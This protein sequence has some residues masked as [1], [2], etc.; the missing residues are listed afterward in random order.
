MQHTLR[1]LTIATFAAFTGIATF[2]GPLDLDEK[3]K[4]SVWQDQKNRQTSTYADDGAGGTALRFTWDAGGR[5][6]MESLFPQQPP[7]EGF[8]P[9]M[10][11]SLWLLDEPAG[12]VRAMALRVVDASGEVFQFGQK[13][14]RSADGWQKVTWTLDPAKAE[15]IYQGDGNKQFDGQVKW[16]GIL[17]ITEEEVS[18][19]VHL[20]V[21]ADKGGEVEKPAAKAPPEDATANRLDAPPAEAILPRPLVDVSKGN[22]LNPNRGKQ[23]QHE[24][25]A[26]E[27]FGQLVWGEGAKPL[28]EAVVGGS[29]DLSAYEAGIELSIPINADELAGFSKMAIR[30]R[31]ARGEIFQWPVRINPD[32]SGWQDVRVPLDRAAVEANYGGPADSRGVVNAPLKL[33]SLLFISPDGKAGSLKLGDISRNDFDAADISVAERMADVKVDL[34]RT[35]NIPLFDASKNEP[36]SL[37]LTNESQAEATFDLVLNLTHFD[38][39][40]KTV[41]RPGIT[42]AGG[43]STEVQVADELKKLGWYSLVPVLK[44]GDEA[45]N[46]PGTSFVYLEP[47]G[48]RAHPPEE[49][50]WLGIDVRIGNARQN[51]WPA[52]L[53]ALIGAD[54]FRVGNTWPRIQRNEGE[55]NT[56]Q[57]EAE[58]AL[59]AEHGLK[60][61]YGLTFTPEWAVLPG[62]REQLEERIRER[63]LSIKPKGASTMP[64]DPEAWRQFVRQIAAYNR[65]KNVI[66]YEVW[67]E[68]DLSGF[69]MGTTD[70]FLELMRIANEEVE[71]NHPESTMLGAGIATLGGHGGHNL[72]PDMITRSIVEGA[73][74]Y[75]AMAIHQHGHFAEFSRQIDGRIAG[76]REKIEV[77]KPLWFTET[78]WAGEDRVEQ[79][80]QLV[81]KI[82]F[83]R[84]RGAMGFT[85]FVLQMGP[86]DRYAMLTS[87]KDPQ[88]HPQLAAFNEL[89]KMMR[90]RTFVKQHETS[91][92]A[93]VLEFA[94]KADRLLVAWAEEPSA[95]GQTVVLAVPQETRVQR[96]DIM[97]NATAMPVTNGMVSVTLDR[98][99]QYVL[100]E[101][102]QTGV[103]GALAAFTQPVVGF[104]GKPAEAVAM[105]KNPTNREATYRIRWSA[106]GNEAVE[107]DVTIAAG[108]SQEVSYELTVPAIAAG[109]AEPVVTLAYELAGTSLTGTL[110]QAVGVA[111]L[112]SA[113]PAAGREPDFVLDTLDRTV[114]NVNQADPNRRQ[115]VWTGPED[116]SARIWLQGGAEA[117]ELVVEVTDDVHAQTQAPGMLWKQDSLQ[118]GIALPGQEGFFEFGFALSNGKASSAA[119]ITPGLPDPTPSFDVKVEKTAD[120]V[121][122]HI[123]MPYEALGVER[124]ALVE[125]GLRFNAVI[126]DDDGGDREGWAQVSDGMARSK[127]VKLW[128]RIVFE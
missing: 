4:L 41:T 38:G 28:L 96:F 5:R 112:V 30:A 69:Y 83:A 103:A 95:Q 42:L 63:G 100:A 122:Y 56:S 32:A 68:P 8:E 24:F 124:S 17:A 72:N 121:R 2:A 23:N 39:T 73:P 66:A 44:V 46:K 37:T 115:Y 62:Y 29:P 25:K 81:K 16:Y 19:P 102:P 90:G 52:E 70:Q 51:R 64:P 104:P 31:D 71:A 65:G 58:L 91:P 101:S 15:N 50:F 106:P 36:I 54:Y 35:A 40:E 43:A 7:I 128:P 22:A 93:W 49:G 55:F 86:E 53:G 127:D 105:L 123:R 78:G 67:N 47:A 97:G 116:L 20:W 1:R 120:G 26:G 34:K 99:V 125:Q 107:K 98:P 57:H 87:G 6:L 84:A 110:R 75:E 109:E 9:G 108:K 92:G 13:L 117:M 48:N 45:A 85:W 88:P 60:A 27:T 80:N 21:S 59:L 77:E 12:G 11:L 61:V 114:I 82:T 89:A 126:N 118:V 113:S 119:Y 18:Q 94:G 14:D 76:Y 33:Q 10:D 79:A 111:R 74:H 3:P